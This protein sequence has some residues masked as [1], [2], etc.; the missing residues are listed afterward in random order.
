[1][2]LI[3]NKLH[4]PEEESYTRQVKQSDSIYLLLAVYFVTIV[5]RFAHITF[6]H[7]CLEPPLNRLLEK[8]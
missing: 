6:Y 3:I 7:F 2:V 8:D 4:F 5:G 1:M